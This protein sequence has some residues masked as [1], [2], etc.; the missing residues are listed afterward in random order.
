MT[1][2]QFCE[3]LEARIAKY[4]LLCHP[5]YKAWAAGELTREDLRAY[6]ADYY[7]HVAAFPEHLGKLAA[8]TLDGGLRGALLTNRAD[9]LGADYP[10]GR[11]HQELWLDFAEGMGA[12]RQ[13]VRGHSPIPEIQ[14]LMAAFRRVAEEGSAAEALA[15]FYA[16]ESQV[17]RVAKEKAR[18]LRERYGAD[19]STRGYFTLHQ[20]ADVHHAQVWKEQ[21]ERELAA[22]PEAADGALDAAEAA[23]RALWKALDGIEERRAGRHAAVADLKT[24]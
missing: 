14:E 10:G 18:G 6:A 24:Q 9:E 11:P 1:F 4:D 22:D 8:R 3:Q 7:P 21:L 17:P 13:E 5:F 23:A 15:A 19:P 20:T 12:Q 16:Y 2:P